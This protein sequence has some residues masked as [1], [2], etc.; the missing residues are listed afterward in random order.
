LE[1]TTKGGKED[2]MAI[3]HQNSVLEYNSKNQHKINIIEKFEGTIVTSPNDIQLKA[4][5][6]L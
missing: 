6:E 5:I 4:S 3:P 1:A 2:L